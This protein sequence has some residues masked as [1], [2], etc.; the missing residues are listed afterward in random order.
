MADEITTAK[1]IAQQVREG[2]KDK[3]FEL[4]CVPETLSTEGTCPET[5]PSQHKTYIW[6]A[7][8]AVD[9]IFRFSWM[10]LYLGV[11]WVYDGCNVK[12]AYIFVSTKSFIRWLADSSSYKIKVRG[13]TTTEKSSMTGCKDCCDKAKCVVFHVDVTA[14]ADWGTNVSVGHFIV[15]LCGEGNDPKVEEV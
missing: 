11:Y 6:K 14:T 9:L 5:C 13:E 12:N 7:H 3:N 4:V 2:L 8:E 1:E 15:T 10:E